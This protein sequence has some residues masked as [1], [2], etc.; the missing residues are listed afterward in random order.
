MSEEMDFTRHEYKAVRLAYNLMSRLVEEH[1]TKGKGYLTDIVR[2]EKPHR[3]NRI[4]KWIVVKS[5]L[6]GID[7]A[8][9]SDSECLDDLCG[10][11]SGCQ[12]A[13]LLGYKIGKQNKEG[14]VELDDLIGYAHGFNELTDTLK[15]MK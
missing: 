2:F 3:G 15:S 5:M 1:T 11:S 9:K 13:Q 7:S 8:Y 10:V 6:E 12:L 4:A 14:G